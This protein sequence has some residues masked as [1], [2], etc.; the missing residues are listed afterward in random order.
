MDDCP[1]GVPAGRL[2]SGARL[3]DVELALDASRDVAVPMPTAGAIRDQFLSP[4]A[5]GLEDADWS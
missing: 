3:E 1:P 4:I 2:S 5:D